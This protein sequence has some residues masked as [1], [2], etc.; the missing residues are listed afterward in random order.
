MEDDRSNDRVH[1]DPTQPMLKQL[2]HAAL[3]WSHPTN[4]QL[5]ALSSS[6][7]PIGSNSEPGEVSP[8]TVGEADPE[9]QQQKEDTSHDK[10]KPDDSSI[11]SQAPHDASSGLVS[12]SQERVETRRGMDDSDSPAH[13]SND[14]SRKTSGR[15]V[16]H[17]AMSPATHSANQAPVH[18]G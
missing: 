13:D 3:Q 1:D 7:V 16:S 4:R 10:N 6:A 18:A 8:G 15:V 11:L 5:S 9:E 17:P 12:R 14:F 2:E